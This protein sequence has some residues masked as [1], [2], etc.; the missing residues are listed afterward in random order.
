MV[1]A[2]REY[3]KCR[4]PRHL[5]NYLRASFARNMA[6]LRMLKGNTNPNTANL[7]KQVGMNNGLV[8]KK[9]HSLRRDQ[10]KLFDT[11]CK[12]ESFLKELLNG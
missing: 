1:E 4:T 2:E 6:A 3:K 11:P 9:L 10:P 7:V 8:L 5:K 12:Q